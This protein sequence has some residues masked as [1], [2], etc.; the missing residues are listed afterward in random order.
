LGEE[1]SWRGSSFPLFLQKTGERKGRILTFDPTFRKSRRKFAG[2]KKG[3]LSLP[4][5]GKEGGD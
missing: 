2:K 4:L 5:I 1:Y 3:V